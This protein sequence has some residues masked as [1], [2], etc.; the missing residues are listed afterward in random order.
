MSLEPPFQP[1]E[2]SVTCPRVP[3]CV[4]LLPLLLACSQAQ[5]QTPPPP[6]VD[7]A[8]IQRQREELERQRQQRPPQ[9]TDPRLTAPR[10]APSAP[11]ASGPSFVL[12]RVEFSESRLLSRA[13][14]DALVAPQ[15][16][17][18]TTFA[19][20]QA[21]AQRINALYF[22][23]GYITARAFV[24]S[25][26]IV[27]GVLKVRLVEAQL[28]RLD[29]PE[30]SALSP[31]FVQELV[32]TPA[33]ALI[34]VPRISDRL[35][36][37]HRGTETRLALNFVPAEG[38]EP[39]LS[40]IKV[41]VEEPP[42]W[43]ARLSLSN[44]G[45]DSVG[46]E[47]VSLNGALNNLLGRTDKLSLLAIASKGST[48]ANLQYSLPL[49]GPFLAW[50]T[51]FTAGLSLGRTRAKSPGFETV[52]LDGDSDAY[53]LALAQPLWSGG[54]WNLDGGANLGHSRS[55][56]DIASQ[57]F[58]DVRSD[59]VGLSLSLARLAEGSSLSGTLAVSSARTR[60]G[61][62]PSRSTTVTQ[63]YL[64]GQQAL[65]TGWWLQGRANLQFTGDVA[66]PS[67]LQFQ[68]GGP[69]TV[70]GYVSPTA[71]GDQGESASLELHRLVAER[72]DAFVFVDHGRSHTDGGLTTRLASA[73]LGLN[74]N[75]ER[76]NVS[77]TVA[78]P[79]R[80]V[81]GQRDKTLLLV[82]ASADLEKF[83]R[84]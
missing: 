29:P 44:E 12:Q 67:N 39:G 51:R 64:N 20:V 81:S 73:G 43:T 23:R 58:S 63:L 62:V 53:T 66:L 78:S 31:A 16:G 8:Q 3:F 60:A 14:L 74:W 82:R 46:R 33:G 18:P 38:P 6:T 55:A 56:T 84:R 76:W 57:R 9:P 17:K 70:R 61:G 83:W 24:P 48:S 4:R 28:A 72:Y 32:G 45:N 75:G 36:R 69:A 68:V 10:P 25:Q 65:A 59:T 49:P 22:D 50:G 2:L 35:Q 42:F 13:D 77:A 5:A 34:D 52:K 54:A 7:P 71:S 79:R 27:D 30:G 37:L 11:G 15:L 1:A 26:K 19:D 21:L 47:Q 40:V 41:Q 80:E